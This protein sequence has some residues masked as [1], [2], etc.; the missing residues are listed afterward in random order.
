MEILKKKF[1]EKRCRA[2][3]P[4][5]EGH[6]VDMPKNGVGSLL[7]SCLLHVCNIWSRNLDMGQGILRRPL[8]AEMRCLRIIVGKIQKGQ[9]TKVRHLGRQIIR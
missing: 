4:L 2:I 3:F 5:I 8:A 9:N 6:T 7:K 1:R